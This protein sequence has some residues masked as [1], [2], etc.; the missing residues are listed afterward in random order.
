MT[1]VQERDRHAEE[2]ARVREVVARHPFPAFVTGF[3]VRLGEFDGDR[4]LW[5]TFWLDHDIAEPGRELSALSDLRR[6][7]LRDILDTLDDRFPYFRFH[8][9]RSR[10]VAAG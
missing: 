5:I 1:Q 2:I 7:V 10:A 4:A 8:R 3:D 9:D 6:V